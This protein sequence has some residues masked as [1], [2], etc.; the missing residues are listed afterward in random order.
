MLYH[1]TTLYHAVSGYTTV[2]HGIPLCTHYLPREKGRKLPGPEG[3]R[4]PL[5]CALN[6]R[7]PCGLYF[8]WTGTFGTTSGTTVLLPGCTTS[9][10]V[11]HTLTIQSTKGKRRKCALNSVV[12]SG[13]SPH[14]DSGGINMVAFST[15]FSWCF[16][17]GALPSEQRQCSLPEAHLSEHLSG[18]R[19][20]PRYVVTPSHPSSHPPTHQ[21][22]YLPKHPPPAT[23]PPT[24][25]SHTP[26]TERLLLL[27]VLLPHPPDSAQRQEGAGR[28]FN[29]HNP[30]LPFD[31]GEQ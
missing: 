5:T 23:P 6:P 19:A 29:A 18:S 27:T 26:Y 22:K 16:C 3:T 8:R 31:C 10:L 15:K 21:G 30:Q 13:L 17:R 14:S 24:Q 12:A 1:S 11:Q 20:D 9:P 7:C 2:K 28:C 25:P 4:L